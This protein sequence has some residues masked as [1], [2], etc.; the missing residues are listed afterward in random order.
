MKIEDL[1]FFR[2]LPHGDP[3]GPILREAIGKGNSATRDRA[4]D[5]LASG[6]VLAATGQQMV[7]AVSDERVVVGRLAIQTDGRWVWPADLSYYVRTYNV[8]L[9]PDFVGWARS[10]DWVAPEL[11]KEDLVQIERQLMEMNP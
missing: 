10:L 1:G 11:S 5:Y 7:D 2:E 6:S 8:E 9:P 4:A 3:G